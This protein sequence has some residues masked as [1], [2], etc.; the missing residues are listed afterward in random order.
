MVTTAITLGIPT[1]TFSSALA[2]FDGYRSD[3]LPANLIQV[4]AYPPRSD[5][6]LRRD[7]CFGYD[8]R[9]SVG[10]FMEVLAYMTSDVF[11]LSHED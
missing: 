5:P 2:F 6:H 8:E 7:V 11:S 1:P 4:S 9:L 10:C 3:W